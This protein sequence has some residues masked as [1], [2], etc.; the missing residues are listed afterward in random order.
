MSNPKS[1]DRRAFLKAAGVTG[2]TL[3]GSAIPSQMAWAAALTK[4][5]RDRM[6]PDEIIRAM[7]NGNERF[8]KGQRSTQD[9][10]AQQK[11]SA[12]GQYPAAVLLSCIDSRAP[13]ETIMD[14]GIGDVFNT[15]VAGNI[16][17][18]DILGSM[19]FACQVA[20]AKVVLVMGHTACGAIKGA[21]DRVQLGNLT[22][23]LAKIQ[24]AIDATPYQGE[25]SAKNY[26]FVD[27]VARKNVELTMAGIHSRSA[28]IAALET[29][30]AV[31]IAGAM[32]NLETGAVDFLPIAPRP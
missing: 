16:A 11:A 1:V 17:N 30:G 19:E 20:G 5:E 10:L 24:P 25:R 7:K 18:D 2:V 31:K 23:L 26:A 6:T 13:A 8:R 4:A 32:Y 28:I 12:K 9:Y 27:A 3:V 29:K 21:I 14:L 15:R 22:G